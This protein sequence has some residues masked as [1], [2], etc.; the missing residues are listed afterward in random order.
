MDVTDLTKLVKQEKVNKGTVLIVQ[1]RGKKALTIIHSGLAE[2]ISYSGDAGGLVP[3]DIIDKSIRVGLIK[4][5]SICGIMGLLS[6]EPYSKSVRTLTECLISVIPVS[7]DEIIQ[8]LQSKMILNLQVL[9]ALVQRNESA[10]FLLNNYKYL[11]HKLASIAD[12]I[13]LGL[14][15]PKKPIKLKENADRMSLTLTDYSSFL[16]QQI[17]NKKL[18]VPHS[19]DHNLFLGNIQN[20]LKLF[21]DLDNVVIESVIDN[22]QFLFIKRLLRKKDDILMNIFSRDEPTNYYFFQFLGKTLEALLKKNE[23][24]VETINKLIS[25][26]FSDS[27]WI[28]HSI[29][30]YDKKNMKVYLFIH[31]LGKFC[32]R[33]RRDIIQLFGKDLKTE[34]PT[35]SMLRHF[36]MLDTGEELQEKTQAGSKIKV[37]DGLIT[38]YNNLLLK[39]LAFS[40][41]DNDFRKKFVTLLNT[42]KNNK[43]KFENES[44]LNMV[45]TNISELYWELYEK[46]FLKII[47]TDLK[48]FIPGIMLHFGLLDEALVSK[49]H[50]SFIDRAYAK[51]LFVDEPVPVMTLPYFLEKIYKM[52]YNPSLTEMGES[53]NDVLKKQNKM[54]KKELE[55]AYL[56]RDIVEDRVRFEIKKV[57]SKIFK[58]VFGS[59]KTAFPILCSETILGNIERLFVEP[60]KLSNLINQF[61]ERDFSLFYRDIVLHHKFGTDIVAKE[62]LP[63]F[64]LYPF[65]GSR[66]MM[67]QELDG[68]KRS[69]KGRLFLPSFFNENLSES[70]LTGLAHFRWELQKIMAGAK[71]MDP[72]DGG[73]IGAYYDYIN[74]YKKNPNLTPE[75]KELIRDLIKRTRSDKERFTKDYIMWMNFEYEGRIK[76]NNVARDIF[77]RY[78]PFR[79]D[80]RAELAKKPLYTNLDTKYQNRTRKKILK[81]ESRIRKFEKSEESL[82]QDIADYMKFL[83][84]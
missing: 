45:K 43:K 34:F 11:W 66:I 15:L 16:K 84:M 23:E 38:K 14:E 80:F 54:S 39:I 51:N 41:V 8:T 61:R 6:P 50:L 68:A 56:Y 18:S 67:W 83:K 33:C 29:K 47:D 32:W 27:G 55:N 9:R 77:Y 48:G 57:T 60:A 62:V 17:V 30:Q 82:P 46:C 21:K 42:F 81:T 36:E 26:L 31:Y 75:T 5:E 52:D 53:F 24:M 59:I 2:L 10:I 3:E 19:W 69:T 76:L 49:E 64:V 58:L 73:F 7:I 79:K 70:I 65:S 37:Q 72:V 1:G 78:C 20:S 44:R 63:N 40:E 4:G 28:H 22:Q 35:Y 74:F 25:I 12:S 71:W 13:A